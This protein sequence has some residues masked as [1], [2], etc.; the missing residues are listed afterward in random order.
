MATTLAN[1]G[2]KVAFA[3]PMF[4]K[5][6]TLLETQT[7]LRQCDNSLFV[8]TDVTHSESITDCLDEIEQ[9]FKSPP[10][11]VVHCAGITASQSVLTLYFVSTD[12]D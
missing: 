5:A 6:S 3:D 9:S 7:L 8:A 4:K 11:L 10:S 12:V 2:M 1:K